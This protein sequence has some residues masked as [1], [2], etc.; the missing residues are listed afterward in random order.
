MIHLDSTIE[1]KTTLTA[2]VACFLMSVLL[3]V[4]MAGFSFMSTSA[5]ADEAAPAQAVEATEDA[6]SAEAI[7][8]DANP[9]ASFVLENSCYVHWIIALGIVGTVFYGVGVVNSR[10]KEIERVKSLQKEA[11]GQPVVESVS[12]GVQTQ[13]Q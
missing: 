3:V 4:V 1:S 8:D 10:R 13:E 9:L 6:A 2:K 7:E 11:L 12:A 5:W